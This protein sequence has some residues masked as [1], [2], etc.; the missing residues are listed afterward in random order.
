MDFTSKLI[1]NRNHLDLL[2]QHLKDKEKCKHPHVTQHLTQNI[3]TPP[4]HTSG[5]IQD[6]IMKMRILLV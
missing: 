4:A 2:T 5:N 1:F 6:I 3:H